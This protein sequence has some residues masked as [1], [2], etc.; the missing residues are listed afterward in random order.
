MLF[1]DLSGAGIECLK[2]NACLL[3][4]DTFEAEKE[5]YKR[6]LFEVG[7]N[8]SPGSSCHCSEPGWFRIY[9]FCKHVSARKH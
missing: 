5:L 9:M 4:S 2:S 8:I 6:I 1:S 7:L 3:S